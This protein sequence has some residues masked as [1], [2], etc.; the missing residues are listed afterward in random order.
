MRI[1][2]LKSHSSVGETT[3]NLLKQ[4]RRKAVESYFRGPINQVLSIT[5]RGKDPPRMVKK[6]LADVGEDEWNELTGAKSKIEWVNAVDGM[7]ENHP[8]LVLTSS[9]R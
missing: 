1:E 3:F 6:A 2:K 9:R 5:A 8:N 4:R 7:I